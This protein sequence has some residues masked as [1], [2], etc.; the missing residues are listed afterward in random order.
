MLLTDYFLSVA[1]RDDGNQLETLSMHFG[2]RADRKLAAAAQ[3]LEQSPLCGDFQQRRRVAQ[4]R[5]DTDRV[6]AVAALQ[7]QR[8]L[9]RRLKAD[10]RAEV[11]ADSM[12]D[13]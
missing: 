7:C 11:L 6:I 4:K 13:S 8:A 9:R 2:A 12:L 3:A 10:V 1:V 5:H